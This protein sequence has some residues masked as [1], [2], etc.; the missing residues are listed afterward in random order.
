MAR[1]GMTIES[2]QTGERLTFVRTAADT[3]GAALEPRAGADHRR[4]AGLSAEAD[5]PGAGAARAPSSGQAGV[6]LDLGDA[7]ERPR[8][9]AAGLGLL[10]V[11]EE[12]SLV[13]VG[14]ATLDVERDLRDRRRAVDRAQL[15]AG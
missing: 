6:E 15:H 4:G 2:P 14:D 8:D 10:G 1:A 12:V 3:G 11:L 5:G 13:D 7:G 9:R